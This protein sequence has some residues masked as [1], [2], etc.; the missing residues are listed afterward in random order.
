MGSGSSVEEKG[1]ITFSSF[2]SSFRSTR[3]ADKG[4]SGRHSLQSEEVQYAEI[5]HDADYDANNTNQWKVRLY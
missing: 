1:A 5:L 2:R 4:T 3:T